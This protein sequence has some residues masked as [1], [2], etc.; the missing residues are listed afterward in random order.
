MFNLGVSLVAGMLKFGIVR[1]FES[2]EGEA[3]V[4]GI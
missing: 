3:A 1:G 2:R 4:W